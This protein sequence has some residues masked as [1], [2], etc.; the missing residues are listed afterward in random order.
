MSIGSFPLQ[1][2][3][4]RCE[5]DDL[6]SRTRRVPKRSTHAILIGDGGRLEQSRSPRPGG[7]HCRGDQTRLD[8]S[9]CGAED[10]TRLKFIVIA[11]QDK[12]R[13]HHAEAMGRDQYMPVPLMD[14]LVILRKEETKANNDSIAR[15]LAKR[16]RCHH[17]GLVVLVNNVVAASV[18]PD[19][20]FI[21]IDCLGQWGGS[22]ELTEPGYDG[23][24]TIALNN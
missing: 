13:K 3:G 22:A 11:L 2:N 9:A 18:R 19:T 17:G 23:T 6:H 12:G 8:G 7:D 15:G 20:S 24:T 16:W 10:F 14:S 5:K 1:F 21:I 4:N